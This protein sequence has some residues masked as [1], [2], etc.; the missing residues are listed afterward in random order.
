MN[1]SD[2]DLDLFIRSFEEAGA[3]VM[4]TSE[5]GR[6]VVNGEEKTGYALLKNFFDGNYQNK[7]ISLMIEGKTQHQ[8]M[9]YPDVN[10]ALLA[11]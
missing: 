9:D 7:E 6:M 8:R 2:F 1:S 3:T 10:E 11:A 5:Q 4:K